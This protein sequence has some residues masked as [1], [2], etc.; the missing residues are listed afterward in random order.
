MKDKLLALGIGGT[1]IAALCCFTPVLV[2]ILTGLGLMAI[3]G[4]LDIVLL[5]ILFIFIIISGVA[6]WR[7]RKTS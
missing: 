4:Y 6:L 1:I 7:R 2:W 5:P 3:A